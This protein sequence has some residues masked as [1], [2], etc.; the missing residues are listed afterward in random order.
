LAHGPV[1][2]LA[3]V[4]ILWR[5]VHHRMSPLIVCELSTGLFAHSH[6]ARIRPVRCQPVPLTGKARRVFDGDA[7]TGPTIVALA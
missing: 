7:A 3:V 1:D 5:K 4:P 2:L 6:Q